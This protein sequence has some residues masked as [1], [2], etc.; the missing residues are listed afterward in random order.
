[1]IIICAGVRMR[2]GGH[3][4]LPSSYDMGR[5]YP[6]TAVRGGLVR[7]GAARRGARRGAHH[8]ASPSA[9]TQLT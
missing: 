8:V 5:V 6:Q 4:T 3:D 1:M 7:G 2:V 9:P